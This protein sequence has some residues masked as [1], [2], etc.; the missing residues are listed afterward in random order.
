MDA[1][2][3]RAADNGAFDRFW[4][5][6]IAGLALAVPPPIA[7]DVD[8]PLL[9]P[10]EPG[11][12]HGPGAFARRDGGERSVDGD[13]PIRLLPEPEA[14]VYRGDFVA[15][16]DAGPLDRRGPRR[17]AAAAAASRSLSCSADAH[18]SS[19]RARRHWR[20]WPRRIGAST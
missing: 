10:G 5:S 20:C 7:I 4:Q 14:G 19:A 2:R 1:W 6:T 11:R 18:V 3:F 13:Q 17:V 9:R 12:R 8:P 16:R 15:K